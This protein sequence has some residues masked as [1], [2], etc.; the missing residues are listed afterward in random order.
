[1]E[2]SRTDKPRLQQINMFTGCYKAKKNNNLSFTY[3]LKA[4]VQGGQT[5]PAVAA[6]EQDLSI[7]CVGGAFLLHF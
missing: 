1:M 4:K 2:A 5:E 6:T 7:I 3:R